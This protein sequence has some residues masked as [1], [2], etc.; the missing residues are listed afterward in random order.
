MRQSRCDL[1]TRTE[2]LE[3]LGIV[4]Y[5]IVTGT[6]SAALGFSAA[7]YIHIPGIPRAVAWIPVTVALAL[8]AGRTYPLLLSR[9]NPNPPTGP[10]QHET[11]ADTDRG[12]D[13]Q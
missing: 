3:R 13:A 4:P 5:A 7:T 11:Q 12:A 6:I 8:T 10:D 9:I 1:T 2:L